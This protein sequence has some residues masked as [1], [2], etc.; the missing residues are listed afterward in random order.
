MRIPDAESINRDVVWV[1][2]MIFDQWR[3]EI[4]SRFYVTAG[5]VITGLYPHYKV[6]VLTKLKYETNDKYG[7]GIID[8][9]LLRTCSYELFDFSLLSAYVKL[10]NKDETIKHFQ[11]LVLLYLCKIAL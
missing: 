8:K 10:S 1:I 2:D 7:F 4:P 5:G 9:S 11:Q 3:G 6:D